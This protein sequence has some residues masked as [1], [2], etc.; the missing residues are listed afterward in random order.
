M[1]SS[2]FGDGP[3]SQPI[4]PPSLYLK[5]NRPGHRVQRQKT[6]TLKGSATPGAVISVNG[7]R[8]ATDASGSFKATV[9]LA[10]GKNVLVVEAETVAGKRRKT[11][12]P[13]VVKSTVRRLEGTTTW[14][15][16]KKKK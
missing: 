13:I 10:E 15:A 5:V 16:P 8:Y 7:V 1:Q 12:I 6:T 2:I 11:E 14:G 4:I 9:A 3:P